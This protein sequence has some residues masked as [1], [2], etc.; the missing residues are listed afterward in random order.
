M[1][2]QGGGRSEPQDRKPAVTTFELGT[3]AA[4]SRHNDTNTYM[5][6]QILADEF[7]RITTL[8]DS[9]VVT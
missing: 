5:S 7:G 4:N 8:C 2:G 9:L 3:M 6:R 1:S